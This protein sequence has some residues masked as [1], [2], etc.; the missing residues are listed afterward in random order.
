[1]YCGTDIDV[2]LVEIKKAQRIINQIH[3]M[4]HGL[5]GTAIVSLLNE[6]RRIRSA[7]IP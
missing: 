1:M 4:R 7:D 6:V 5:L 3:E 2:L